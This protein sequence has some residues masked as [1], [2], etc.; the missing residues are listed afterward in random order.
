VGIGEVPERLLARM[1]TRA[2]GR[3]VWRL[4]RRF[5]S[6]LIDAEARAVATW[7]KILNTLDLQP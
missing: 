4:T 3:V 5:E 6:E 7:S 2:S 1:R